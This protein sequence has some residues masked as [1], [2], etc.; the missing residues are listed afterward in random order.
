MPSIKNFRFNPILKVHYSRSIIPNGP[1]EERREDL[2]VF[3]NLIFICYIN[4]IKYASKSS[5]PTFRSF[6]IY[7][8]HYKGNL[9]GK[10]IRMGW[11]M[12]TQWVNVW[13]SRRSFYRYHNQ[14]ALRCLRAGQRHKAEFSVSRGTKL[15]THVKSQT[16]LPWSLSKVIVRVM[17]VPLSKYSVA[18]NTAEPVLE[19]V[20]LAISYKQFLFK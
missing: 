16:A 2:A 7:S 1:F 5:H 15:S 12:M 10:G 14:S 19:I 11:A 6:V 3:T 4:Y 18:F 13:V 20:F 17:G 8:L 9:F